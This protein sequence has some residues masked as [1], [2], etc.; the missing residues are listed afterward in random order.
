VATDPRRFLIDGDLMPGMEQ[1]GGAEP[2]NPRPD[3]RNFGHPCPKL[4]PGLRVGAVCGSPAVHP[5]D[6]EGA[7]ARIAAKGG[8]MTYGIA[9]L[10]SL[11]TMVGLDFVWL[12]STSDALYRRDLGPLLAQDPN[13]AIAALFYILYAAGIVIF[14]V[15]PALDSVDWRTATF[16]GALFGF[17]AY[18]TYDLT[19]FATMKVWSLRI[20]L[21]DIGWG[22]LVTAATA[23]VSALAA[24]KSR[25]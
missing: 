6:P 7:A 1:K 21:L 15:R 13:L 23:S 16:Y 22:A 4:R 19:N 2:R 3:D 9:Y 25:G 5:A 12:R 14:A 10:A 24:M 17:F 8:A 18:A 20:T 11:L